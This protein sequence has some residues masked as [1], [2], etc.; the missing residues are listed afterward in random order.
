MITQGQER[1][2]QRS[3]LMGERQFGIKLSPKMYS[4]MSD[5]LYTDRVGSVVRE[6]CSNAWDAQK[7]RSIAT[8][9]PMEPFKVTLPTDLEPHFVV[10]D[11]GPGMPDDQA[12]DLYST[13]G[14][15][16]KEFTN[17]Q[18]GAFGLGSKSPFAVTDTFT[19]ENTFDGITHHY[20]V[21]KSEDGLPSLL[22]TGQ[23]E[24]GR[25]S[26]VKV[27]IPAAG[28]KYLEYKRALNRQL[29]VMEPKPII[30]NIETFDFPD[31]QKALQTSEGFLL[32]NSSSFNISTKNVYARMGMVLYPVDIGQLGLDYSER[33]HDKIGE[34][35]LVLE[36]D[37]GALEPLPSR[38]GLTYDDKTKN[39]IADKYR[40]FS[41]SYMELLRKQVEE[42]PT[43]LDAWRKASEL[44][45]S[46]N[47]PLLT[48]NIY[49]LGFRID[50]AQF[51]NAFPFFKH[52]YIVDVPRHLPVQYDDDGNI[53]HQEPII[54][55]VKKSD[56]ISQFYY[57]DFSRGDTRLNIKRDRLPM[58][59]DFRTL[60]EIDKGEVKI[61][62]MDELEPKYR[63]GRMKSFLN[64]ISKSW[65]DHGWVIRVD[66]RSTA[67]KDDFA[68]FI[69][70]FEA[71][72]PGITKKFTW[73]SDIP[74]PETERKKRE[75]NG[76]IDGVCIKYPSY[77]YESRVKWT[78]IDRMI[79][80]IDASDED[81]DFDEQ[82]DK[83]KKEFLANNFY[84]LAERNDLIGY[85][86]TEMKAIFAFASELQ[87]Q[88]FIV[89]KTGQGKALKELKE[90][91][92][93][94]FKEFMNEKLDGHEVSEDYKKFSS[95]KKMVTMNPF[96]FKYN[97]KMH[98]TN[99]NAHFTEQ[100]EFVHP[101]VKEWVEVNRLSRLD[102]VSLI[103]N[104]LG[105]G[106]INKLREANFLRHF[107]SYEWSK[108]EEIDV[109]QEFAGL[110][111]KF[112]KYYPAF[113][114]LAKHL[115]SNDGLNVTLME[116]IRDYNSLRGEDIQLAEFCQQQTE[117]VK[118]TEE[119]ENV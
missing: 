97:I 76:P 25:P 32:S 55:K 117:E 41:K 31:A 110:Q 47:L 74:K 15:S 13:L 26:G 50:N 20:L 111:E 93:L 58:K 57:E 5:K 62:I 80:P 53:V 100:E 70:C 92:L 44:Q 4:M 12:Q 68:E 11:S 9:Q 19:V 64:G 106:L 1:Q 34:T 24:D 36:F 113:S 102:A 43:P 109:S 90:L 83:A 30:A 95:A 119:D 60:N 94:E 77:T 61:L 45:S 6:V 63:I 38:E 54:D 28:T 16:T 29:V 35:T 104:D 101:F 82:V 115:E 56:Q 27:M 69:R 96:W 85:P 73:F 51:V 89:R 107:D 88:V 103:A 49:N 40:S 7:M 52:D 10:E 14:L 87:Y 59:M 78:E 39:N 67:T 99:I 66:D 84:I 2:I 108:V 118:E 105:T 48:A 71:L 33:F 116:Y 22:K 98:M 37:I 18:I 72:H 21:F 65:R 46:T 81:D 3:G 112:D 91:G 79:E 8:G 23:T 75:E 17:D 42:Q 114:T 86:H